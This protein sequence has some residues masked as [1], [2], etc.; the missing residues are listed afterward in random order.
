[1]NYIVGPDPLDEAT[2]SQ[3]KELPDYTGALNPD[4]LRGVRVGVPRI[5]QGSEDEIIAAFDAALETMRELGAEIVDPAEFPNAA[6]LMASDAEA[7]VMKT[8]IKV[9]LHRILDTVHLVT[10]SPSG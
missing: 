7:L 10:V 1:M 3:P 5:F 6:E 4:A 9:N 2:L 8:D